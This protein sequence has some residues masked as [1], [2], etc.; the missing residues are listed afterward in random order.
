[1]TG[2][3]PRSADRIV[4][5]VAALMAASLD[6][7]TTLRAT[8]GSI[9]RM[10]G[11]D[12][13]TCYV[14]S[15]TEHISAVYT[16]EPDA[17]K[18]RFLER[19]IGLGPRE[20]PLLRRHLA[21]EDSLLV[22]E[23]VMSDPSISP[24]LAKA[25]GCG[26]FLGVALEHGSVAA[27]AGRALLGTLFCSYAKPRRFSAA[28]RD[29]A[30]TLA[31]L[32]ALA[33]ANARLHEE[34]LTSLRRVE[35]QATAS[36]H[37]ARHDPLT[38]L[39]NRREFTERVQ[40]AVEVPGCGP[41]AVLMVDLDR[42]KEIN[43]TLGHDTGDAMLRVIAQ[44]LASRLRPGDLVARLGGDEFGLLLPGVVEVE[45]ARSRA[46]EVGRALSEAVTLNGVT[47]D[48][49][50]SVGV[51]LSPLHGEDATALLQRAD[52]AMYAA[53]GA[54][55]GEE[56]YSTQHERFSAGHLVLVGQLRAA[57][58]REELILHYQPKVRMADD[59]LAGVE[60]LVRW[61]HPERGLLSPG[62]FIPL[63]EHTALIRPLTRYVLE[64]SLRQRRRWLE[65]GLDVPIAVNLAVRQLHDLAFPGEVAGLL[66]EWGLGGT[67]IEFEITESTLMFNPTRALAV[68]RDLRA[69]GVRIAIDDF[70]T[71]YSSLDYLKRVPAD[72]LKVDRSFVLGMGTSRPDEMIVRSTIELAHN[73]GLEVVA[74]GIETEAAWRTLRDLGCDLGQGYHLGRPAPAH[75][76]TAWILRRP[77]AVSGARQRSV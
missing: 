64:R 50:A 20:V 27:D 74:E 4:S 41:C 48:V 69:L 7:E 40:E 29:A 19:S 31:G 75:E 67:G 34:T 62:D 6:M 63:A 2:W 53:K 24:G 9:Q 55:S 60:A 21:L 71:G 68:L 16:T 44:R 59:A 72:V 14:I 73:L 26:A 8:A 45:V 77:A 1:M 32:A 43:D 12:R 58:E 23:D 65:L 22:V 49:E 52:V 18:R 25:L 61:Q 76:L 3:D 46:R 38:G 13:A 51:A 28:E 57:L 30:R 33:L 36:R 35:E 47:L 37:L 39:P 5:E 11:A 15:E 17:E 66:E 42:F 70:G 10:L 56:I 54:R